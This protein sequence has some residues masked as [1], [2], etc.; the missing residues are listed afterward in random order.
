[1]IGRLRGEQLGKGRSV[2]SFFFFL[3]GIAKTTGFGGGKRAEAE[4]HMQ[5]DHR[6]DISSRGPSLWF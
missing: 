2:Q 1:M 3:L 4:F 5:K 6:W